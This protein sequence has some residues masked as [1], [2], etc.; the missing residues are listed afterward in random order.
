M[1]Q[2]ANSFASGYC[3]RCRGLPPAAAADPAAAFLLLLV[4]LLLVLSFH[5][6]L[7]AA[8]LARN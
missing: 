6:E 7:Y 8:V 5:I 2:V 3:L 1:L 4:L